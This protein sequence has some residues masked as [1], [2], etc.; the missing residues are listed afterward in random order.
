MQ[1]VSFSNS[2][3]KRKCCYVVYSNHTVCLETA[4]LPGCN[5]LELQGLSTR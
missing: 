2:P 1:K 4:I 5:I 3:S